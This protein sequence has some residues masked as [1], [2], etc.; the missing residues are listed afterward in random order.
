[1]KIHDGLPKPLCQEGQTSMDCALTFTNRVLSPGVS[2]TTGTEVIR[3]LV[4]AFS[5]TATASS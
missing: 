2:K 4:F 3:F 1:M 5:G